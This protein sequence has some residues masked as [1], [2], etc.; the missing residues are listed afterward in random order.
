V[1]NP[2][3]ARAGF[4]D[5]APIPA[6]GRMTLAGAVSKTGILMA[7]CAASAIGIWV[8][9]SSLGPSTSTAIII[10]AV[11]GFVLAMATSFVPRWAP[12]TA[13]LYAI[14]EG[15][16]LGGLTLTFNAIPQYA[17]LPLTAL[18]LTI[19]AGGVMLMLYVTRI[20]RVTQRFR[21]IM[22][23]A[24]LAIMAFYLITMVVGFFGVSVPIANGSSP[25]SI[26]ISLVIVGVASLSFLLDF[27]MIEQAVNHGSPRYLEWYGAFGVLVTFVWL[28]LEVL[29]LLAKLSGRRN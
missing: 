15:V 5:A 14:V 1:A 27:D 26:G 19:L 6:E 8:T 3:L 28:Y 4:A 10:A 2:F 7:L 29:R 11:I 23:G 24:M 20:V 18:A 9:S 13:P 12:I 22:L 17:G 21:A 25:L 16:F